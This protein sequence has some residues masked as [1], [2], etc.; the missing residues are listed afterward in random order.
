ME[1][2]DDDLKTT[3]NRLVWTIIFFSAACVLAVMEWQE[4]ELP[5][6]GWFLA[7]GLWSAICGIGYT[8]C[9]WLVQGSSTSN[10]QN[11][12]ADNTSASSVVGSDEP[13]ESKAND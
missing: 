12:S 2:K 8:V 1:T 6:M 9:D 10:S 4:R 5:L 13:V 11:N 3:I 7:A